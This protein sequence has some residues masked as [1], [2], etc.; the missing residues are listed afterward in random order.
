MLFTISCTILI[1]SKFSRK[2]E[3]VVLLFSTN[4]AVA[5]A[6]VVFLVGDDT[7]DDDDDEVEVADV[8]AVDLF[9]LR[10]WNSCFTLAK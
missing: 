1:C 10:V 6:V 4:V 7:D 8:D 5:V 9:E 3:E 2:E